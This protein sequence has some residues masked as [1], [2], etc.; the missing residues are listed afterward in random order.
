MW[1]NTVSPYSYTPHANSKLNLLDSFFDAWGTSKEYLSSY[2]SKEEGDH[3]SLSIDLPGAKS[4]D[5]KVESLTGQVKIYGK[6]KGKDFSQTY[7]LP[8]TYDP[9][10][11]VAR[12]EDGVLNVVFSKFKTA[13]PSVYS[14]EVK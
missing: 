3:L 14:I 7:S 12:L 8:K 4:T 1:Y 2:S 6:Q 5:V 11:G 9:S 13:K 10:S